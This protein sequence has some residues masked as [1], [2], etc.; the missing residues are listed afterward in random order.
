MNKNGTSLVE[1]IAVIVVMGIIASIATVSAIAV[2]NRQKKNATVHSLNDIYGTA[3]TMLYQV[4]LGS[5][6]EYIE[7]IDDDFYYVSLNDM[8]DNGAVDGEDYRTEEIDIYFCYDLDETWVVINNSITKTKPTS[9]GN[10]EV[11]DV[12]VTFN[13]STDKFINA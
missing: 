3:K 13:Y 2:I 11:K 4:K 1:V 10:A 8:I 6:D 7:S 5:Y 9:T 12:S